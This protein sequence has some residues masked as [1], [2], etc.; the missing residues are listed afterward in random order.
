MSMNCVLL[1]GAGF[2]KNWGGRLARE[3]TN[4]LMSRLQGN[5][6]LLQ[7]LNRANF[8]DVLTQVQGEI[9]SSNRESE[10]RLNLLQDA[11]T[12]VFDRMNNQFEGRQFE[13]SNDVAHSIQ[14]F[15]VR[16]D[17]IFTLNQDLLLEIHYKN[18]NVAIWFGT[19]WQGYELPG[20]RDIPPQD[21]LAS[22]ARSKWVP[23][24]QFRQNLNMQPYFKLHGSTAWQASDGSPL[25]VIGRDKVGTMKRHPILRWNYSKFEEYLAKPDT[26][27]MVIGYGFSDD[28]INQTLIEAH[29][30][31]TFKLMYLVHPSGK[32]ILERYPNAPIPV[33]DQP[34]KDIP[35]VECTA[36]LSAAF[37]N[38]HMA[39]ELME[40]IFTSDAASDI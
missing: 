38:D 29:Q 24:S 12:S 16:F 20:V 40:G 4:D 28:H 35:C 10:N 19:R 8:E 5:R 13:F 17:A 33:P 15:L 31:G 21:M 2:S 3:V 11:I 36:L 26:R 37:H 27:L 32:A 30:R 7:L 34:L 14:K 39:R 1:T 6:H 9:S 22:R 25:L 23:E 18:Q